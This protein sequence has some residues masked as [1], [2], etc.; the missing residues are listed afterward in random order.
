MYFIYLF[1]YFY[2]CFSKKVLVSF[3]CITYL[4]KLKQNQLRSE[5]KRYLAK[6]KI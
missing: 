6:A 1:I 4:F 3:D 2:I 5:L